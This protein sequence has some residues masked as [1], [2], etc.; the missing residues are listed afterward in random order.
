[1]KYNFD[2]VPDRSNTASLKWDRN[3][4]L[5]N[6]SGDRDINS[7]W[8]ADMDFPCA[9]AIVEAVG[10][11]ACHPIYG[12]SY[13]DKE[14]VPG[15]IGDWLFNRFGWKVDL[16]DIF[17]APGVVTALGVLISEFTKAGEGVIIQ[18]PVYYPFRRAIE[19]A[20]RKTIENPLVNTS[21]GYA[22]DFKDLALK[23]SDPSVTMM[24]LCSPHNPVGRVWTLE[25]L[26]K[27]SE[28]CEENHVILISDEIHMDLTRSAVKFIPAALA[29]S[30]LNTITLTAPSKTFNVPGLS[31]SATIIQNS[32][33]KERW[34]RKAYGAMGLSL[35]NPFGAEVFKA[36]YSGCNEWLE[37]VLCYIDNNFCILK[38]AIENEI[39]DIGFE[40][41][42]GTYL[43]WLDLRAAGVSDDLEFS[44]KLESME[45]LL[46]DPGSIFGTEGIGFIRL[47]VACQRARVTKAVHSIKRVLEEY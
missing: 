46:V 44:H 25:E 37:Q 13:Y 39:P 19:S 45:G 7:M 42:E 9:K 17:Y 34:R 8:V 15:A 23:A 12:Y 29:G 35:P 31:I 1:M 22:M 21:S 30:S 28:I 24:V 36:A 4:R 26:A 14:Q 2:S 40:I 43:A 11:R 33:H 32:E 5:E 6:L 27:L 18:P 20:G 38:E 41:P 10:A 16:K 47:N 3:F